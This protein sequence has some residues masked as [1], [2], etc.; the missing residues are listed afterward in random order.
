MLLRLW[1]AVSGVLLA[2]LL[3][4]AFAPVLLFALLVTAALGIASAAMIAVARALQAWRAG[5]DG[6]RGP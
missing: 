6:T 5:R 4:W 1:L 3:V 2:A